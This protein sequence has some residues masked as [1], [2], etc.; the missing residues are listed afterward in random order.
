[1]NFPESRL[2]RLVELRWQREVIERWLDCSGISDESHAQLVEMLAEVN[3]EL[4]VVEARLSDSVGH[5]NMKPK[6]AG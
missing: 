4:Q 6:Q 1:L 5:N 3:S 2:H